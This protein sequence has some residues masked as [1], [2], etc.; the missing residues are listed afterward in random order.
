MLVLFCMQRNTIPIIDLP[1]VINKNFIGL[2]RVHHFSREE[3][4]VPGGNPSEHKPSTIENQFIKRK[5]NP[6]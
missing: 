6:D 1:N 5:P 3:T 4:G 2:R